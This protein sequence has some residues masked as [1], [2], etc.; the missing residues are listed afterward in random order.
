MLCI[1]VSQLQLIMDR[2]STHKRGNGD[3]EYQRDDIRPNRQRN[4]LLDNHDETEDEADNKNKRV[5]PPGSLLVVLRH[6]GVVAV[7]VDSLPHIFESRDNILAP[8]EDAV[9]NQSSDLDGSAEGSLD[10]GDRAGP[11]EIRFLLQR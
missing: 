6:V 4:L 2:P 10:G 3:A 1:A 8:E 7:A 9:G 5:P 11:V